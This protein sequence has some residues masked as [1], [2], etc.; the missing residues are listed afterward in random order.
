MTDPRIAALAEALSAAAHAD[1]VHLWCKDRNDCG[2]YGYAEDFAAAILD[3]LPPDWCG[4]EDRINVLRE[5]LAIM[6]EAAVEHRHEIASL[7]AALERAGRTDR[8]AG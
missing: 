3:A 8:R 7:R 5:S 1:G 2:L 4:H 6:R